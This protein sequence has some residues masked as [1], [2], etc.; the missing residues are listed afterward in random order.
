MPLLRHRRVALESVFARAPSR[1]K[2]AVDLM[3]GVGKPFIE[4][5]V[6]L[7]GVGLPGSLSL[8][9]LSGTLVNDLLSMAGDDIDLL[10]LMGP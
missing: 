5:V 3:Y 6:V 2:G 4:L 8:T 9:G 7:A 1:L 10:L